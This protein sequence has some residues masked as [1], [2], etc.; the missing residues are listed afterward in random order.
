M[1]ELSSFLRQR[2]IPENAIEKLERDKIDS[3]VILVMTDEQLQGYIPSYGDRLAVV[4]FCRRKVKN[5]E[6]RHSKLLERL[7]SKLSQKRPHE[8]PTTEGTSALPRKT[9]S[10]KNRKVE[11]G[12]MNFD[13]EK[14]AFIQVRTRKG[15]GTRKVEVSRGSQKADLLEKAFSLFFPSGKNSVGCASDFEM[16][17]KDFKETSLDENTT[18]GDL[19]DETQLS[20]LRFYLTTKL[21][22]KSLIQPESTLSV[23]QAHST[24]S[25]DNLRI[26]D[27]TSD[28]T[29]SSELFIA[30]DEEASCMIQSS[31]VLPENSL[32]NNYDD[33]DTVTFLN[34]MES[35]LSEEVLDDTLPMPVEPKVLILHRGNILPELIAFF[36]DEDPLQSQFRIQLVLPNGQHEMAH[37]EGGVLRDC[38]SEFWNDFYEQCTMGNQ[39]KVPFLRHD[40]AEKEWVSVARVIILGWKRERYFPIKLAPV[41]FEQAILGDVQSDLIENFLQYVPE[42][43]RTVFDESRTDFHSVDKEELFEILDG[44][45]CRKMPTKENFEEILREMAHKKFIQE[46]AFVI[47]QWATVLNT[48][49]SDLEEIKCGYE[50]LKPTARKVLKSLSFP[51]DPARN[52]PE[53]EIQN[54]LRK[55][56]KESEFHRLSKFLRFC[57]GS[58]LYLGKTI[59]VAFTEIQGFKRRP[60]SHTCGCVLEL[61]IFYDSYPDFRAEMNKVLDSNMWVMDIV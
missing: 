22:Q 3:D 49:C 31:P 39:C 48:I 54:H 26:V 57:T 2:N 44:Y 8:G 11:I 24:P 19:Y 58:D 33:S 61:S 52:G 55:Y 51:I 4:S 47:D 6:V 1:D 35:V 60:V 7:R 20:V 9:S 13:E 46:P 37:D 36:T 41:I 17:I 14:N 23:P 43:E 34:N 38:L 5:V 30:V 42:T 53:S 27:D 40:F 59:N 56:I 45:S 21:K 16:D 29:Q 12:W 10:K 32:E 50:N 15:G 25:G 28:I 18:V